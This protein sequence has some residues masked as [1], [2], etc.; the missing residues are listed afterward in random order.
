[1]FVRNCTLNLFI[2]FQAGDKISV[3]ILNDDSLHFFINGADLGMAAV[4][5]PKVFKILKNY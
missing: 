4:N 3:K 5:M 1:M 2:Y